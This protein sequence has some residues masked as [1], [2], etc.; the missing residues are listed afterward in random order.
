[1]ARTKCQ[2]AYKATC[3]IRNKS[4]KVAIKKHVRIMRGLSCYKIQMLQPRKILHQVLPVS[5]QPQ[6]CK[7]QPQGLITIN[8][9]FG[10]VFAKGK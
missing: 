6:Q 9:T 7:E 10:E 8:R 1:M 2:F 3:L 5:I 4:E